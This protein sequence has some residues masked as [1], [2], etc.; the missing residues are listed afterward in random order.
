MHVWDVKTGA[1][2][3]SIGGGGYEALSLA[4]SP[5]GKTLAVGFYSMLRLWDTDTWQL[6]MTRSRDLNRVTSVAFT[7]DGERVIAGHSEGITL[8][9]AEADGCNNG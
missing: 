8:W 3:H 2:L 4:I 9:D 1:R 6:R 5:D 7:P